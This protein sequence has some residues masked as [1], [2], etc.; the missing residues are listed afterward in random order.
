MY[1]LLYV[2]GL[3]LMTPSLTACGTLNAITGNE[4]VLDKTL[5]DEKAFYVAVSA[6]KGALVM[7]NEA[8]DAG[9]IVP[10]SATAL[11]IDGIRERADA[12]LS[13]AEKAKAVGDAKTLTERSFALMDLVYSIRQEVQ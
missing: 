6:Y 9:L 5:K 11:K 2:I 8:L 3:A 10:G 4:A 13:A 7:V 1:K 12:V